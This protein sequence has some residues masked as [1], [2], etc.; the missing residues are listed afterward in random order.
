MTMKRGGTKRKIE[1]KKRDSKQQRSVACSK[2][3]QTLFSKAADLCLLS[4]AN[5]AV[6]VTSPAENSDV[7]YSFSGYSPASEIADCYLNGRSPPKI[8]NT[9]T[10]LGFWWEDLDLYRYC[11]D[12]CELKIIEDHMMRT[13]KHL[14][15]CIEKI[16]ISQFVSNS[17]QNPSSSSLDENPKSSSPEQKNSTFSS[18]EKICGAQVICYDQNPSFRPIEDLY[19]DGESAALYDQSGYLRNRVSLIQEIQSTITN[20]EDQSLWENLYNVFCLNNDDN[21]IKLEVP[22]SD[23]SSI[24]EEE[25]LMID[26][27]EY[28]NEEEI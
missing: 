3:R 1:I 14:M 6:F 21:N 11:D 20:E 19:L 12:L 2:R 13:K 5:I 17:D 22:L 18:L 23:H 7:V 28:V 9:Q 8:T 27:S 10:K 25:E 24:E 26:I 16:E 15:D 4:G